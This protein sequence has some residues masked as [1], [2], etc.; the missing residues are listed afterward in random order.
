MMQ[1]KG[2]N[3]KL[4]RLKLFMAW[5]LIWMLYPETEKDWKFMPSS[6][7]P[8]LLAHLFWPAP[9]PMSCDWTSFQHE[10]KMKRNQ[11]DSL[12]QVGYLVPPL[13]TLLM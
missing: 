9:G 7:K 8:L 5:K 4:L 3:L 1:F 10:E 6:P 11:Q 13:F 2:S 12:T